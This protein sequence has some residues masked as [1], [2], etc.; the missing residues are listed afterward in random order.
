M[1]QE[2]DSGLDFHLVVVV[3]EGGEGRVPTPNL[4]RALSFQVL[5]RENLGMNIG[6]WDHGWRACDEGDHVLFLQDECYPVREGWLLAFS[7]ALEDSHVGLLGESLNSNWDIGWAELRVRE[8]NAVMME[9]SLNGEPSNRID[10]YLDY[11]KRCGVDP[12]DSAVHLRS[13]CWGLRRETLEKMDGFPIGANFGEC[14]A[15]E[16]AV[17]KRVESMGLSVQQ[18]ASAPFTFLRHCEWNQDF[19]EG[20]FSKLETASRTIEKLRI[21]NQSLK[22]REKA[23]RGVLSKNVLYQVYALLTG[24]LKQLLG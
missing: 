18:L 1:M 22:A 20:P 2:Y 19:P 10:V 15:A 3:N 11:F 23:L 5:N 14:I 17:S 6:A 12:G 7:E 8:Q 13:L 24:R 21:E 9:H 16:I 4:A